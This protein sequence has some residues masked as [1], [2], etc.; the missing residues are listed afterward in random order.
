MPKFNDTTIFGD[1]RV[2]GSIKG[3]YAKG[4][5]LYASDANTLTTLSIGSNGQVLKLAAGIP[6]WGT[7]NNTIYE[8]PDITRTDTSSSADPGY[9]QTFTAVDS[10]TSSAQGHISAINLKTVKM[11]A[12]QTINDGTLS[13][14]NGGGITGSGTFTANQSGNT[15]IE[16]AHADTS[17]QNSMVVGGRTYINSITLDTYGHVTALGTGTEAVVDTNTTYS[18]SWVDSGTNA[19]LRLTAG[20]SGSG[21]ND[22]TLVAGSNITL[23]PSGGNLTIVATDTTYSNASASSSGLVSTGTQTFAGTKTFNNNINLAGNLNFT[24]D[25]RLKKQNKKINNINILDKI[26]E[27]DI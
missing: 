23:T 10:I 18:Q 13:I 12:A 8:H 22:L 7:D 17:S 21:N 2:N 16:I 19:I 20:G 11:P 24:S 6:Y 5:I 4:D 25:E 15:A 26:K 27:V 1:L 3:N 14:S 9:G